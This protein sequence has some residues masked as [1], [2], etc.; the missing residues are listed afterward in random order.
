MAPPR[1]PLVPSHHWQADRRNALIVLG[2][3]I[4][5][6]T[7]AARWAHADAFRFARIDVLHTLR[8]RAAATI[9]ESTEMRW[10]HEVLA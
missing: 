8:E 9:A 2:N 6:A 4:E 5:R 1:T 10:A 7:R 3:Q